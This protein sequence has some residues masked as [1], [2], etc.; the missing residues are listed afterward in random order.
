M[1]WIIQFGPLQQRHSV[2][3]HLSCK[4]NVITLNI[5]ERERCLCKQL[6]FQLNRNVYWVISNEL[7]CVNI[8][9]WHWALSIWRQILS[10]YQLFHASLCRGVNSYL[11]VRFFTV[12]YCQR[13][14]SVILYS[15]KYVVDV[16]CL[17]M[18]Y[19]KTNKHKNDSEN[20]YTFDCFSKS[21][22][23]FFPWVSVVV[24]VLS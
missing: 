5:T 8:F 7:Y 21:L 24:V 17:G 18:F 11:G 16:P 1:I 3:Q 9:C 14:I 12:D 19:Q 15:S 23:H 22:L 2:P 4:S 13:D 20:K 6:Y 10:F